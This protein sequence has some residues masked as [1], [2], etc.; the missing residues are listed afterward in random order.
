M[1]FSVAKCWGKGDNYNKLTNIKLFVCWF[2]LKER[3]K[4]YEANLE[5]VG[6]ELEIEDKSVRTSSLEYYHK[7]H[8]HKY[9]IM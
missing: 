1:D 2:S 4:V 7:I 3:R 9:V 5:N 6:L 8:L